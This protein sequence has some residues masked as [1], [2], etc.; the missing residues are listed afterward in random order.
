MTILQRSTFAG[1]EHADVRPGAYT[2]TAVV[3]GIVKDQ[4]YL[5]ER[6][7]NLAVPNAASISATGHDHT[8]DGDGALIRIPYSQQPLGILLERRTSAPIAAGTDYAGFSPV[9]WM[10]F[11]CPPG[12][13][14]VMCVLWVDSATEAQLL[15]FRGVVLDGSF[16]EIN[17]PINPKNHSEYHWLRPPDDSVH[18]IVFVLAASPGS[19]CTLKIEAW[20]GYYTAAVPPT[21]SGEILAATRTLYGMTFGPY[22]RE[23]NRNLLQYSTPTTTQNILS[24]PSSFTS[25]DSALIANDH[26]L[27]GYHLVN[28]EKNDALLHE[29]LTD[30]PAGAE[31]SQAVD[32]H[33]HADGTTLAQAGDN[34]PRTLAAWSY[35]TV[36]PFPE[37]GTGSTYYEYTDVIGNPPTVKF[38][39]VWSGGSNAITIT[40]TA[41][42]SWVTVAKHLVRIPDAIAANVAAGT[43]KLVGVAMVYFDPSKA[44]RLDVQMSL[45]DASDTNYGAVASDFTTATGRDLLECRGIQCQNPT[46]SGAVCTLKIEMKN[47]VS[48]N[49]A[50]FLYGVALY[51][52]P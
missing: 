24:V 26:G 12:V 18:G 31:A 6:I 37:D 1:T 33:N 38:A 47:T 50:S 51:Y 7:T 13:S 5:Y 11:Y 3:E 52:E 28:I 17:S 48:S 15:T 10:P 40:T 20:D 2:K 8:G 25:F 39:N 21:Q 46:T 14:E 45:G 16:A 22:I 27:S 35:G 43:G 9:I 49:S 23:P 19:V 41:G 30:K 34:I 4:A 36:R 42:T 29:I 32:G 44:T